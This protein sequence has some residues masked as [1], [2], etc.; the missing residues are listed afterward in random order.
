[1]QASWCS[2]RGLGK[3]RFASLYPSHPQKDTVCV[4]SR[5]FASHLTH[6]HRASSLSS[7]LPLLWVAATQC[8]AHISCQ[9]GK[10]G[11]I[12][13]VTHLSGQGVTAD[14]SVKQI[15]ALPAFRDKPPL[16]I[17]WLFCSRS[18]HRMHLPCSL[19]LVCTSNR[20]IVVSSV[21]SFFF[22]LLV[23]CDSEIESVSPLLHHLSIVHTHL[24]TE[25]TISFAFAPLLVSLFS[26]SPLRLII[27]ALPRA[28]CLFFPLFLSPLF[29]SGGRG[30]KIPIVK[31]PPTEF[32]L[33]HVC[34][35]ERRKRLESMH[36]HLHQE[37]QT[38]TVRRTSHC[39]PD[40][41]YET[42]KTRGLVLCTLLAFDLAPRQSDGQITRQ[43]VTVMSIRRA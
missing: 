8:T 14:R 5:M 16:P 30:E 13:L 34:E 35:G 25:K 26:C 18:F 36:S 29:F 15:Q 28:S 33:P 21:V 7:L 19:S 12:V 3:L 2:R 43:C 9:Q 10:K 22:S 11:A 37:G 41:R 39:R 6:T 27:L 38:E 4:K 31:F 1:V 17:V 42:D 40:E 24:H 20:L 23:A 32:F